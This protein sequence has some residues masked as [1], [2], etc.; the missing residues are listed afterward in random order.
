MQAVPVRDGSGL[1]LEESDIKVDGLGNELP[2]AQT[3]TL[4]DPLAVKEPESVGVAQ[5]DDDTE[6]LCA[7]VLDANA[8]REELRL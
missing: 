6:E 1:P 8:L 2:V 5:G 4:G 7:G 3:L